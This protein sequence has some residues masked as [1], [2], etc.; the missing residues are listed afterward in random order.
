MNL[1]KASGHEICIQIFELTSVC[2]MRKLLMTAL[3]MGVGLSTHYAAADGSETVERDAAGETSQ[4]G[5]SGAGRAP[6]EAGPGGI[7]SESAVSVRRLIGMRVTNPIHE[8][9]GEVSDL[10]IDRC[11]RIDSVVVHAGGFLGIGGRNVRL[12]L[13]KVRIRSSDVSKGLVIVVRQTRDYIMSD[14]STVPGSGNG[15]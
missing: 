14:Q 7:V 8:E 12:S 3:L 9:I 4:S 10:V 5:R 6:C 13:D 2:V 15:R 11:G 1:L